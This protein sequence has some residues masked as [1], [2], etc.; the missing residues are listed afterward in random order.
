MIL[1][2]VTDNPF[3]GQC[4]ACHQRNI[5]EIASVCPRCG[6]S[7]GSCSPYFTP[8]LPDAPTRLPELPSYFTFID[9]EVT[10]TPPTGLILAGDGPVGVE[11]VLES[12]N[13]ATAGTLKYSQGRDC[14]Q[15]IERG[16]FPCVGDLFVLVDE[17]SISHLNADEVT[18][19]I[20]SLLI[21]LSYG[22]LLKTE[23]LIA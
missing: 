23:A 12:C 15:L 4:A 1:V 7:L 20:P 8:R 2:D 3:F 22:S 17:I 14:S 10:L 19:S 18:L 13:D 11:T 5:S 9:Y 21:L 16:L 6:Y